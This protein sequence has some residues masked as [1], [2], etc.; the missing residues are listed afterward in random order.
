MERREYDV[1]DVNEEFSPLMSCY[2]TKLMS[3]VYTVL[4][5]LQHRV[6]FIM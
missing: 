2:T 4:V 1:F 3:T 6:W 5:P